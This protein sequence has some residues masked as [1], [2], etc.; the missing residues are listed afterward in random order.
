MRILAFSDPHGELPDLVTTGLLEGVNRVLIA[1]DICPAF[2]GPPREF[3]FLKQQLWLE[4]DFWRWCV[5]VKIPIYLTLGNHDYVDDFQAVPHLHFGTQRIVDDILLFSWTPNWGHW[6]AWA[7]N[8]KSLSAKLAD[9]LK[10]GRPR[11]W[12]THGAPFGACDEDGP[13]QKFEDG[14]FVQGRIGST[15]L[16]EGI[17]KYQPELVICGHIHGGVPQGRL[18][19]TRIFNVSLYNSVFERHREPILIDIT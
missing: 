15:A 17:L 12:L 3:E 13:P 16:R 1:G 7:A 2:G 10:D 19:N 9:V 18:G 14:F 6:S 11:I 8:E 5:K 4:S